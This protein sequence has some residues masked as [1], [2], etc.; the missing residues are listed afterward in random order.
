MSA[1]P[2][3]VIVDDTYD[4]APFAAS[5]SNPPEQP[6]I[7]LGVEKGCIVAFSHLHGDIAKLRPRDLAPAKL[8]H[9]FGVTWYREM[10]D[11]LKS[12]KDASTTKAKLSVGDFIMDQCQAIGPYVR[13]AE[14]RTGVWPHPSGGLVINCEKAWRS[15]GGFLDP[16]IHG[17]HVYPIGQALGFGPATP[18]ATPMEVTKVMGFF[19]SFKWKE[20]FAAE[21][22]LGWFGV[23]MCAAAV[24][25]RPHIL[26][27]GRAGSGKSTLLD[28]LVR[29]LGPQVQGFTGS[30]S[31]AGLH[32]AMADR[33]HTAVAIDEFESDARNQK[34]KDTLEVA[35]ASYSLQEGDAGVVRGGIDGHAKSYRI[36]SCFIAAGVSPGAMEPADATRWVV[37]EALAA[38]AGSPYKAAALSAEDI[39]LLGPRMSR[40]F[41][42]RWPVFQESLEVFQAAIADVGGDPRA[43]DTF[44]YLLAGYWAFSNESQASEAEAAAVVAAAGIG[45]RL[46]SQVSH[47]EVEC[48]TA[49]LSRKSLFEVPKGDSTS[50]VKLPIR[51]AMRYVAQRRSGWQRTKEQLAQLGMRPEMVKGSWVVFVATSASHVELKKVFS[52]TKWAHGGW[53]VVLRRLPGGRENTQRLSPNEAPCKVV[54][55]DLPTE[56]LPVDTDI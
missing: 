35:R 2:S 6:Y 27:T 11:W 49:L 19:K 18:E 21:F 40:L 29:L 14:R 7:P 17:S 22:L 37:L 50:N 56:L 44:G 4:D 43:A 30:P 52:G 32:Q 31:L 42:A 55:F 5:I 26:I 33:P 9:L 54:Q 15:T 16:G 12:S 45:H 53:G 28:R 20:P 13:S 46:K 38:D 10:D 41:I 51:E 23:A 8:K 24:R 47:D 39:R 3:L 25:R 34:T 1:K 36:A 48:L